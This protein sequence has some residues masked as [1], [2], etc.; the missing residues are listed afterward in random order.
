MK[1]IY[2][3]I[4]MDQWTI[5]E[6]ECHILATIFTIDLPHFYPTQYS[7][8]HAFV[9]YEDYWMVW[10][11]MGTW[12][13]LSDAHWRNALASTR[14][15]RTRPHTMDIPLLTTGEREN[16]RKNLFFTVQLSI[17]LSFD[18]IWF[19][20]TWTLCT[21]N[22]TNGTEIEFCEMQTVKLPVNGNSAESQTNRNEWL[23]WIWRLAFSVWHWQFEWCEEKILLRNIKV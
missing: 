17:K 7:W 3:I 14:M 20:T 8:P 12:K 21:G 4:Q 1:S 2:K 10:C 6:F 5:V 15:I 11:T 22:D 19:A 18:S 23:N 16:D 9:T 13:I